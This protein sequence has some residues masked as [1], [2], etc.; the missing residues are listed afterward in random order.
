MNAKTILVTGS[1]A[2]IGR[3]VALH[4]ARGGHRVIATGRTESKLAELSR[5]AEAA[6]LAVET[7]RLDVTDGASIDAARAEVDRLTDGR[8]LDVLVNNAGFGLGG[9]VESLTD[10][11]LRAQFDTNVFGL[12]AVTRAFLPKMRDRR[13]GTVVNVSSMGG[14][15]TFPYLGAYH[16]TKYA[17]EAFSDA[18]RLE[19]RPFGV[20]VSL[21]EPGMISTEFSGRAVGTIEHK[22]DDASPYGA[23]VRAGEGRWLRMERRMSAGP[24]VIARVVERIAASRRP[25]ARYV[26][27]FHAKLA[28]FMKTLLP[29][30]WF[31]ALVNLAMGVSK[32]PA[33]PPAALPVGERAA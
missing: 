8:G 10:G 4:L 23:L 19:L 16:A 11:E 21:V 22:K 2:G 3:A 18:L 14:R 25:R 33:L 32:V 7:V 30:R 27:P 12:L 13:A 28:L 6:G 24:E 15:I 29:T 31:D 9:P 17:V 5:E 20:A 1:T 26:A